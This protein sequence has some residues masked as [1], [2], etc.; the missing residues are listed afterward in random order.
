[1]AKVGGV[2][3]RTKGDVIA[4]DLFD[5]FIDLDG[6]GDL[7]AA[8]QHAVAASGDFGQ[9]LEYAD[10]GLDQRCADF[11]E[12][13]NMVLGG[14]FV[15]KLKTVSAFINQIRVIRTDTFYLTFAQN[16][17]VG[18]VKERE[19][20]RAAAG[21]YYQYFHFPIPDY[22]LKKVYFL[23]NISNFVQLKC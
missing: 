22:L 21:I 16:R 23:R 11:V 15:F 3:Q 4:D 2:V 10:F 1:M 7:V 12:G 6:L 9:A 18:H 17:F 8:Q 20:Q 19:F 13:F 14:D 5:S